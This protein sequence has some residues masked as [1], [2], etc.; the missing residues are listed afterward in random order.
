MD[1]ECLHQITVTPW[2]LEQLIDRWQP[3]SEGWV[4]RPSARQ[5]WSLAERAATNSDQA[6]WP[7]NP[8]Q[9]RVRRLRRPQGF[10][11]PCRRIGSVGAPV[12]HDESA[13]TACGATAAM[14]VF[15]VRNVAVS[16]VSRLS[17]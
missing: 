11:P 4:V 2:L 6:S 5:V 17:R 14:A 3:Q 12:R 13:R 8:A 7:T 1:P 16:T 10:A 9:A 15:S